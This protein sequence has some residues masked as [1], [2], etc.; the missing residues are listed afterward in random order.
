MEENNCAKRPK[1]SPVL[2]LSEENLRLLTDET[3][4]SSGIKRTSSR[5]SIAKSD[6][7]SD[8]V[9]DLTKTA[10]ASVYRFKTLAAAQ[11]HIHST[12]SSE[13]EEAIRKVLERP[14]S[15][16][17]KKK[18]ET[19]AARIKN[20]AAERLTASDGE[21]DFLQIVHKILDYVST[22]DEDQKKIC[23]HFKADWNQDLKPK[24]LRTV[25]DTS[26]LDHPSDARKRHQCDHENNTEVVELSSINGVPSPNAVITPP[27][28]PDA[29][30]QD[31][32]SSQIKTPRPDITIG[33]YKRTVES[34]LYDIL[35]SKSPDKSPVHISK[36]I[37]PT[38]EERKR[39]I[40]TPAARA[41]DLVFPF[42][43]TEGKAYSTG[44]T[45]FQAENQAAVA[46]A[47]GLRILSDLKEL[48]SY[49]SAEVISPPAPFLFFS[50]CTQGPLL[51]LWA[52]YCVVEEGIRSFH[53]VLVA[54]CHL[55]FVRQV[56]EFI[57]LVNNVFRWGE[58][59]FLTSVTE[60]LRPLAVA[61]ATH[62]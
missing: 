9:S 28:G 41:S 19:L 36:L 53:A 22:E 39:V 24:V 26:F 20:L 40:A 51:E 38:L 6:A 60:L 34:L 23:M 55:S 50:I 35:K 52:H 2:A 44:S 32:E 30:K 59:D 12:P 14:V 25:L 56:E 5:R 33:I 54:V 8:T 58:S 43:V 11:I 7:R 29:I 10:N 47:C 31:E 37:L 18:L 57:V 3:M 4:T 17:R 1:L 62:I 48:V 61:F 42:A 16:T 46:A 45:L 27:G 21:D 49:A 13:I 15:S